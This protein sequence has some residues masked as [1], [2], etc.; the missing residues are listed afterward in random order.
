MFFVLRFQEYTNEIPVGLFS[1]IIPS[2]VAS[3][4]IVFGAYSKKLYEFPYVRTLFMGKGNAVDHCRRCKGTG[5]ITVSALKEVDISNKD[6]FAWRDDWQR[7]PTSTQTTATFKIPEEVKCSDC[8]G[9][10]YVYS[11]I[12]DHLVE[13]TNHKVTVINEYL[14]KKN[15]KIRNWNDVM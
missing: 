2:F 6:R 7:G 12:D 8:D 5:F 11:S 3:L 14:E 10:G 13:E 9:H 4:T 1:L 15:E